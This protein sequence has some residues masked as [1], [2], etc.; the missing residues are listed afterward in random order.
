MSTFEVLCVTMNQNDFSKIKEMNIHS[1]VVFANQADYVS[2]DE[3]EFEGNKAKMITTNTKGVGI[4][5]NLALMYATADICMLA[6]DDVCYYDN[7]QEVILSEFNA[8]PDADVFIF[9]LESND[10]KRPQIKYKKTKKCGKFSRLSWGGCRIAIRTEAIKKANLWFNS[11]M[12]GGCKFPSGEDSMF[13]HEAKLKGLVFYVSDKTIGTVNMMDSTWFTGHNN[14]WFYSKGVF[15][16][17]MYPKTFYIW[18]MYV[19][20]RNRKNGNLK[21]KDKFKWF[22]RGKIGYKEMLGF[23]EFCLKYGEK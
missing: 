19:I 22:T 16:Y 10:S 2:Y 1:D 3:L 11:L 12:G 18:A 4:N 17:S 13:L 7:M 20:C 8:Y 9:H 23:E 6:D 5:R 14:K 21:I 15:H